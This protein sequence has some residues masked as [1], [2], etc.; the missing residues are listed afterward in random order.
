MTPS[1][2]V[3]VYGVQEENKEIVVG[4]LDMKVDGI[5]RNNVIIYRFVD[6]T[7]IFMYMYLSSILRYP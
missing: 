4:A 2:R 7:H 5:F 6:L 1:A 3:I